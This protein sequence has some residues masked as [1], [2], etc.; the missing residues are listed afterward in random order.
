MAGITSLLNIAKQGLLTHQLNLQVTGHNVANVNT[1]GYSRQNVVLTPSDPTPSA[2][3]PL[4]NGVDATKVIR[5]YDRFIT[6]TLFQKSSVMSGLETRQSGMKLIEGVLNEVDENGLNELLS[7]FWSSWDD[8]A[9]NA[10]GIAE[11]ATLLQRASLL[12]Q[13]LRDRYSN[14]LKLSQDIDLNI[15]TSVDDIN[16]LVDQ[17]AELNVQ[18]LSMETSDHQANDLRDKR[19]QLLRDLSDLADVHY[20]ETD[21]GTYTVLIGQGSP[22]VESD[23]A[24]H[25]EL[26]AGSVYWKGKNGETQELTSE[27][28]GNGKLGGYLD[29]KSRICPPDPTILTSSL[30]NT[31]NG[32]AIKASTNWDAI[33]GVT[34]TGDF[35]ISFSG[36]DQDGRPVNGLFTYDPTAVPP[37]D[38]VQDF[39]DAIEAAFQDTSTVPPVDRVEAS[40]TEDGRIQ[41]E[42]LLPGSQ[43]I[44]FQIDS[45]EG[46]VY[47]LNLGE[48]DGSYPLNYLG[49]LNKI[50]QELIKA[51][52]AQHAQGVGLLPLQETSGI[53][54]A[55]NTSE[56]MGLRSSGLK[57]SGEVQNGHFEIWLYDGEGNVIDFDPRTPEVNDPLII[58]VQAAHTTMEDVRDAINNAS[59]PGTGTSAG[60]RAAILDGKLVVQVSGQTSTAGFAFGKDTS[61]A[62]TAMGMNAFFTGF[63]AATIEVN[64]TLLEDER[65]VAA[66]QV[67]P[68]GS[69][70]ASSTLGLQDEDRPL[71]IDME[72][73]TITIWAYDKNYRPVDADDTTAG[74]SPF[75]IQ[76]DPARDSLQDIV[77]AI[78]AIDGLDAYLDGQKVRIEVTNEDWQGISFGPDPTGV[79]DYMGID[80]N[81]TASLTPGASYEMVARNA[82]QDPAVPL[83]S[84]SSGLGSYGTISSGSFNLY[85]YDSNGNPVS[86][87]GGSFPPSATL[88]VDSDPTLDEIVNAINGLPGG[89]VTASINWD[90]RLV[91]ASTGGNRVILG[92]DTSGVLDA[93]GLPQMG[94]DIKGI[95][96]VDRTAETLDHFELGIQDGQ[97]YIHNYDEQG[98]YLAEVARFS[99][100]NQDGAT[101]APVTAAT[102]W[103]SVSGVTNADGTGPPGEFTIYFSGTKQDGT[104]FSGEYTGNNGSPPP[105]NTDLGSFLSAVE[106]AFKADPADTTS[107]VDAFFDDSGNL[108]LASKDGR[109]ISFRID[110]VDGDIAGLDF[111]IPNAAP[112]QISPVN[113]TTAAG[114]PPTYA[115]E[116]TQWQNIQE[117]AGSAAPN[118]SAQF[119]I[120][121]SG[122]TQDGTRISGSYVGNNGGVPNDV[123]SFLAAIE[124]AFGVDAAGDNRVD[125]FMDDS[126][127][128]S[129][130]SRDGRPVSFHIDSI[131]QGG[132]RYFDRWF[133]PYEGLYTVEV[134]ADTDGLA[135]IAQRIDAMPNLVASASNGNIDISAEG[136]TERFIAAEDT[137]GILGAVDIY[138]PPGG[139]LS[140]AN[141]LNALAVRDLNRSTVEELDDATLNEAYQ[142]LVGTVGIHS[143]SFQLDYDFSKATV[144]ELEA[145]RDEV[146][147]VSLDAE[148]SDLLRFQHAYTAAAKLIKAADEM[149]TTL[150]EAK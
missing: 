75:S 62:L 149:F 25:L 135:E 102:L 97:F 138:S 44:S 66:A 131:E 115:D 126:G 128:I 31:S 60:L 65:L 12:A 4:G 51:V 50:G 45:I 43:D 67:Q 39:L 15:S 18:I 3:G 91:I 140:P 34:V 85:V 119:T 120:N 79:L 57:F 112:S 56:P 52:N 89:I 107:P 116:T 133:G 108:V 55:A 64:P 74:I 121:F 71:G 2:I 82:V 7:Q 137:S 146:S 11:R 6:T 80:Q 111:G 95:Y 72:S 30:V 76:V 68:A 21:R 77:D 139:G 53:Y 29:I 148:M 118:F 122:I 90:G 87:G 129:V 105:A 26:N 41:I 130:M 58:N 88:S 147:G 28:I 9:N 83:N 123:A 99:T 46:H 144:T 124:G 16:Q 106:D 150:L 69:D 113:F 78:D 24:W 100:G 48:F 40:V 93:L 17:I 110:T 37:N 33:D 61:G 36:T 101:S 86:L 94:T 23:Q 103:N 42:D 84:A 98:D 59:M 142:A 54:A 132:T 35:T 14:L 136:N 13:G 125:A 22:L 49:Q 5:S 117:L 1:E 109:P 92:D 143:R 38:S 20:F 27:D 8:V 32:Q 134:H 114:P 47:G 10:E 19:D 145:R 96:D 81:R 141:N 104:T 73:G 63:D 127:R 70:Q